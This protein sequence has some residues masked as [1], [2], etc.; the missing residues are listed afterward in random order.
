MSAP[1][2]VIFVD[3]E[4]AVLQGL[5]R[6]LHDQREAW[7]MSFF[8]SGQEALNAIRQE[9]VDAVVTDMRMPGMDGAS[10]LKEVRQLRP[11]TVR[12][13]LSGQTDWDRAV[14]SV[15]DAH[16]F[17]LKPCEKQQLKEAI[18]RSERLQAL[19][20]DPRLRQ[21][22]AQLSRLPMLGPAA[23]ELLKEMDKPGASLKRAAGMVETEPG[24]SAL[25]LKMVHSAFFNLPVRVER[26]AQ[27]AL[28][29]GFDNLRGMVM[30]SEPFHG[31]AKGLRPLADRLWQL[32]ADV[33]FE[34]RQLAIQNGARRAQ[35][36]EAFTAGMLHEIGVLVLATLRPEL[37]KAWEE[38]HDGAWPADAEEARVFGATHAAV[39]GY[40]LALWGL[41]QT[42][43]NAVAW[44]H[45]PEKGEACPVLNALHAATAHRPALVPALA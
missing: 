18:Q 1:R 40:L 3:D 29:L 35:E 38:S 22:I 39:G 12:I 30:A 20:L 25:A 6:M 13:V 10:L 21:E 19:V 9:S 2:R 23:E 27:A 4:P 32:G 44:H 17:L 16:Q 7:N 42:L 34:A 36:N 15:Q 5:R 11:E 31:F 8:S 45:E 26:P 33:A 28:L 37:A 41:P 24:L 14:Q 43:V